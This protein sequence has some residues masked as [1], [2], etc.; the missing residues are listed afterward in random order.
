MSLDGRITA[1]IS[2]GVSVGVNCQPCL[3]YYIAKAKENGVSEQEI[4]EA[5]EVGQAVKK[6]AAYKMDEYIATFFDKSS[7]VQ[8]PASKGCGCGC[9][10]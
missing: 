1:L 7:S 3:Q 5:I 4:Q 2:I 6:G 10:C 9:L 8:P